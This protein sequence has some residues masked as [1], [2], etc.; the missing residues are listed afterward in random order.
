MT[1]QPSE[2]SSARR[3]MSILMDSFQSLMSKHDMPEDI[4]IEIEAF[5]L[6][7]AKD[8]FRAGARSGA[9]FMREK[10]TGKKPVGMSPVGAA[11]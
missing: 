8:Q 11:A 1:N 10:L 9:A 6:S 3:W 4:A 5:V 7:V 2:Q